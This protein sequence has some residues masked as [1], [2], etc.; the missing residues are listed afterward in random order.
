MTRQ[1][2]Q[3]LQNLSLLV[4]GKKYEYKKLMT[5]GLVYEVQ[6]VGRGRIAKRRKLSPEGCRA[7]MEQTIAM[8]TKI[9]KD[10]EDNKNEK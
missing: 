10:L 2:N 9:Q 5:K 3:E 1:E 7:Y 8:R 6:D 4:F